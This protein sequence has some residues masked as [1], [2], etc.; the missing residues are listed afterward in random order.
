MITRIVPM[1]T[2]TDASP[3]PET[4]SPVASATPAVGAD[5]LA[6]RDEVSGKEVLIRPYKHEDRAAVR[7]LCADTGFLSNPIDPV[8]QDRELFADYLTSYYTDCEPE[9]T[10][11]CEMDGEVK[12][13]MMGCRHPARQHRYDIWNNIL[14]G[15]R[16]AWRYVFVYNA[17]SRKFVRWIIVSAP[18]EVPPAPKDIPH[19]HI[20]LRPEAR[21]VHTTRRLFDE[22][23]TYMR[24]CGEKAVYAQVVGYEKRRGARMFQRYGFEVL[25]QSEVTKFKDYTEQNI[26]IMTIRKDLT[27]ND[28]IY[29]VDL[30]K[31]DKTKETRTDK[32]LNDIGDLMLEVS[33]AA[34]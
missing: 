19:L 30:A 12:G 11:I 6:L 8:F 15:I 17:A 28:K 26:Y 10:F 18:K 23:L 22:M 14:L 34:V 3:V 13:Y 21:N 1:S 4:F 24:N 7:A 32:V 5:P 25:N 16:G 31:T 20:N 27:L 29:G 33:A 2:P 9:S